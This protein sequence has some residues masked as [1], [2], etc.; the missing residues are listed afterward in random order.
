MSG[1]QSFDGL[2]KSNATRLF[3]TIIVISVL[4]YGPLLVA[5]F[6]CQ[7]EETKQ[8][9]AEGS[10]Y[11]RAQQY[12]EAVKVWEK[13]LE[14]NSRSVQAHIGLGVCYTQ[15]GKYKKAEQ[16]FDT[17]LLMYPENAKV[18]FNR[19]LLFL[20]KGD[21]VKAASELSSILKLDKLYPEVHY[22][23]GF[24]AEQEGK[25]KK[26]QELYIQELNVNPASAKSWYR[27]EMLRENGLV[28]S[29]N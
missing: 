2:P 23:L 27:L 21:R 29:A 22:H 12:D 11:L 25:Y 16:Y 26:A 28:R 1:D 7:D 6:L 14:E 4:L 18:I 9:E 8:L 15:M 17:A 20:H 5:L 24:I 10:M 13:M 19:A 3:A